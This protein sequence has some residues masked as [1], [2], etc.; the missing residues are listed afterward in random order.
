[1][2]KVRV[3]AAACVTLAEFLLLFTVAKNSPS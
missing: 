3:R 2:Y 1:M